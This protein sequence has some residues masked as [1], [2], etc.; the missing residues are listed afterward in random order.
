[1][2]VFERAVLM[3][4]QPSKERLADFRAN[5]LPLLQRNTMG[6][7]ATPPVSHE[8]LE[9]KLF[10]RKVPGQVVEIHTGPV[11]ATYHVVLKDHVRV[12]QLERELVDLARVCKVS[13][14][15]VAGSDPAL[16]A[17]SLEIPMNNRGNIPLG[18]IVDAGLHDLGI[19][20]VLGADTKGE[21]VVK[22]LTK[23]PHLLVAG[24][25]GSGKSVFLNSLITSI[26]LTKRPHEVQFMMIDPK[27]VELAPF[28]GIPHL[29]W[30]VATDVV[31]A[32]SLIKDAIDIMEARY[33][34]LAQHEV[35]NIQDYNDSVSFLEQRPR[36]V[37][38]IDEFANL[39]YQHKKI[40][41]EIAQLAAKGR[42]AGVHLVVATQRPS[43][44]VITGIIKANFDKRIAFKCSTKVDSGVILDRNGGASS[45]LGNGDGLFMDSGLSRFQGAY[46]SDDEIRQVVNHWSTQ[47]PA[48]VEIE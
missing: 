47:E 36:L 42:A 21:V 33:D 25:T 12:A 40:D 31:D 15:R 11:V 17:V 20:V 10:A 6:Y 22:D 2:K 29:T 27:R 41:A 30:P 46:V 39:I 18:S 19:P 45:L 14:M 26:L 37:I 43:V 9:R 48:L 23:M 24:A 13:S 4:T 1:M 32:I 3:E 44:D 35:R 28:K 8:V 38:V 34:V 7:G 5:P 16:S